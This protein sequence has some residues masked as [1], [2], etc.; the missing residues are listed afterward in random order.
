[1]D[2]SDYMGVAMNLQSILVKSEKG[3]E[4]IETRKHKLDARTRALLLVVNGKLTA[5]QLL[6]EYARL[7]NVAAMLKEL[8]RNGFIASEAPVQE[9][10]REVASTIYNALGPDS[11][12][13][14]QEVE[15]CRSLAELRSYVASR[16]E[17]FKTAL[18]EQRAARLMTQLN[19]LLG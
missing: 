18:D 17:L 9:V 13:L 4:E 2:G 19:E 12:A 1:M 11:N 8:K 7:G 3:A 10:R 5:G 14:T 15:N 6:K 16:S